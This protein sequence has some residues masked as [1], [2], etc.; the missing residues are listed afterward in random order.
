M[1]QEDEKFAYFIHIPYTK[2]DS[3]QCAKIPV[4]KVTAKQVVLA[5]SHQASHHG[6]HFKK[7][8]VHFTALDAWLAYQ[9]EDKAHLFELGVDMDNTNTRLRAAEMAIE[10]LSQAE[11]GG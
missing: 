6:T 7:D 11:A 1:S 9:R 5:E 3:P 8:Q 4:L 10:A 2:T